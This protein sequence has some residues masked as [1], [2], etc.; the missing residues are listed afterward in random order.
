MSQRLSLNRVK[1]NA[2][3]RWPVTLGLIAP[4]QTTRLTGGHDFII[5][6]DFLYVK[7]NCYIVY[8]KTR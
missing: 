2:F 8:F 4:V 5:L 7:K 1:A 6:L 3:R